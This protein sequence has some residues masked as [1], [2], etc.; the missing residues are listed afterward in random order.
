MGNI[1]WQ[2]WSEFGK[3]DIDASAVNNSTSIT[4]DRSYKDTWNVALGLQYQINEAWRLNTGIAYDTEM[5]DEDDVTPDLPTGDSWRYGIGATYQYS[6]SVQISAGYEL[7]WY[8]DIDMEVDRGL[9]NE[10]SGTYQDH[11]IHFLS[12]IFNWIL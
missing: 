12:I 5:V 6:E 2:E 7:L 4:A 11:A 9:A 8:G 10:V 1:G 3:V